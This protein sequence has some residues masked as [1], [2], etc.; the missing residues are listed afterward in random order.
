[1]AQNHRI[2]AWQGWKGPL[3][4]IQSKIPGR[5][6]SPYYFHQVLLTLEEEEEV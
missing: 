4:V 5:E 3:G 2:P 1:M 6:M